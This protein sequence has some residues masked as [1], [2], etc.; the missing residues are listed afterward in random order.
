M[1]L[2]LSIRLVNYYAYCPQKLPKEKEGKRGNKKGRAKL[3]AIEKVE[4]ANEA[5]K[6]ALADTQE[7]AIVLLEAEAK[8]GKMIE[9]IPNK[10]NLGSP[11]RTK[12]LPDGVDKKTSHK[13][14]KM[15]KHP[16]GGGKYENK[17]S[18]QYPGLASP[19]FSH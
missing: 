10:Y 14:Q 2:I 8:L 6:A 13:A 4:L 15:A 16:E 17:M 9:G 11:G 5:K 3:K 19:D 7:L 18:P 1:R 12:T